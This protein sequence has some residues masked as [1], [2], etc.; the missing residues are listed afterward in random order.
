MKNTERIEIF[1]NH[2][3]DSG[4]SCK[5]YFRQN[6][7]LSPATA[8]RDLRDAAEKAILVKSGDKRTAKYRY[9]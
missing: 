5:D 6:K 2:I 4:F 8:S 1:R 7:D 3:G 9:K